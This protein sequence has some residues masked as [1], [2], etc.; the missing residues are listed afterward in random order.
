VLGWLRRDLPTSAH[1]IEAPRTALER[2]VLDGRQ[3]TGAVD[4][5]ALYRR[6]EDAATGLLPPPPKVSS[7]DQVDRFLA[8][9]PGTEVVIAKA[10]FCAHQRSDF[11][12]GHIIDASPLHVTLGFP[13]PRSPDPGTAPIASFDASAAGGGAFSLLAVELPAQ[14]RR[15]DRVPVTLWWRIDQSA[16]TPWTVFV[17]FDGA[18]TRFQGDHAASI[19]G[20]TPRYVPGAIVEDSFVAEVG[21][22]S[23][24][25]FDLWVGWFRGAERAD[26]TAGADDGSD[27]ARVG[28]ITIGR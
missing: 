11:L 19:C 2:A 7:R 17:H 21:A 26:V 27:R 12:H 24:G 10:D 15:G 8:A 18:G 28:S 4:K 20:E 25:R 13:P 5:V 22:G 1:R 9:R 16:T 14:A 3:R 23:D 6:D